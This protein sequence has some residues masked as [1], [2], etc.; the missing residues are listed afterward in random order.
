MKSEK[1]KQLIA[2]TVVTTI[3][4]TNI[5]VGTSAAFASDAGTNNEEG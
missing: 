5:Y 2:T 4:A 3:I 1:L